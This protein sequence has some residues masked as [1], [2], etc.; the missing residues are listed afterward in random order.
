MQAE[1]QVARIPFARGEPSVRRAEHPRAMADAR[2]DPAGVGHRDGEVEHRLV[3]PRV[4]R[5][6][7]AWNEQRIVRHDRIRRGQQRSLL[8]G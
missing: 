7:A 6:K 3:S 8:T 1:K 5:R 4:V 2:D